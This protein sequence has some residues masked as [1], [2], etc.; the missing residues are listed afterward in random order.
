MKVTVAEN[1]GFC[2]GVKRA[3]DRLEDALRDAKTGET[4]YTLGHL[5]HN[6]TYNESLRRRG[7]QVA[8][9][10][11]MEEIAKAATE[12]HPATVLV[13]AHGCS[14]QIQERLDSYAKENPYF[15]WIDCTCPYVKKIHKIAQ[16]NSAPD[17]V[18]VLIGAQ[19]H[20]E[21]VGIMSYFEGEKYVYPNAEALDRAIP[22]LD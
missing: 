4:V 11:T 22:S 18:F 12:A 16:E 5:I 10:E 3:T 21:V 17:R 8:S 20:P 7:V 13:R 15:H 6:E 19:A 1:A 2:F 9:E 14:K